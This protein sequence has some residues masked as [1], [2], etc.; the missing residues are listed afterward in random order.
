M[1]EIS[2]KV[3]DM[4]MA[5]PYPIPTSET[6]KSTELLNLLRIFCLENSYSLESKRILDA[7]TG[8]GHRLSEVASFFINNDYTAIDFSARS[9]EI[10]KE[11][12]I[13]KS[14]KNINFKNMNLIN[15]L[16]ELGK[17]DIILCMGVLHHLSE[18]SKGLGNLYKILKDNGV[19]FLYLYGKLGG[20]ARMT[21]KQILSMLLGND[22]SDYQKGIKLVK[23][24]KFDTFEYG[25]NLDYQNEEERN[26]LI[27]DSFLHANE[28]LYDLDDIHE[29]MSNTELYGYSI[30][31]ITRNQSGMLFDCR[32]GLD[33]TSTNSDLINSFVES[34]LA[35]HYYKYLGIRERCKLLELLYEPNGYTV[36][37]LTKRAYEQLPEKSRVRYNLITL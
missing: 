8:T 22:I 19:I 26:S 25:W 18:P 12:T 29:L 1:D 15:D 30:F 11:I 13:K 9:L 23:E 36:I 33:K 7:G 37:G 17:F 10:A 6:R 5:Y 35:Q 27:V 34:P 2:K 4:Y 21:R 3:L 16:S 20:A 28:K 31:G 32:V 14:I 24:L